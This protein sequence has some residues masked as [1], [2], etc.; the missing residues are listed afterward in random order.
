MKTTRSSLLRVL[1]LPMKLRTLILMKRQTTLWKL[2]WLLIWS[3][4]F[5]KL[6]SH[7]RL[8]VVWAATTQKLW[9]LVKISNL[10]PI[11]AAITALTVW[12]SSLVTKKKDLSQSAKKSLKHTVSNCPDHH[13]ATVV[14]KI[15]S[16]QMKITLNN[17]QYQE[18]RR[19]RKEATVKV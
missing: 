17:T 16:I 15:F 1:H 4:K 2:I 11:W 6:S 3:S 10:R 9:A 18:M 8:P 5:A 12:N 13:S 14:L 7:Q 19:T